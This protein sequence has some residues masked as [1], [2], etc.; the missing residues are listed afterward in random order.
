MACTRLTNGPRAQ[1]TPTTK[2][3]TTRHARRERLAKALRWPTATQKPAAN[4]LE[5]EQQHSAADADI[6]HLHT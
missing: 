1:L 6:E 5:V 2:Q 3:T 4:R